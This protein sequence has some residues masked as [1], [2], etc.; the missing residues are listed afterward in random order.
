MR[1]EI[2][3]RKP[4]AA[5]EITRRRYVNERAGVKGM[6]ERA[7]LELDSSVAVQFISNRIPIF[8]EMS[9]KSSTTGLIS[10]MPSLL[11]IASSFRFG[12][13]GISGPWVP[14]AG[15]VLRKTLIHSSICFLNSSLSM[16]PSISMAPKKRADPGWSTR[17][18]V[19][20]HGLVEC[21]L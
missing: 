2:L 18:T 16:K 13:P 9:N 11:R 17:P 14:G 3:G 12:S 8:L 5:R 15:L 4:K 7:G 20:I 1:E 6:K 19:A 10:G 21:E